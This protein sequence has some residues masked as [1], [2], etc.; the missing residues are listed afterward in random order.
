MLAAETS[1]Y[2]LVNPI[3]PPLKS[4]SPSLCIKVKILKKQAVNLS[5]IEG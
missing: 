5:S 4:N 3:A 1:L 2:L